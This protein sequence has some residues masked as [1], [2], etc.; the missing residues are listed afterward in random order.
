MKA[1]RG[2]DS[3]S[4]VPPL[5]HGLAPPHPEGAWGGLCLPLVWADLWTSLALL[6]FKGNAILQLHL[7]TGHS[8]KSPI[9]H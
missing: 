9:A 2:P 5:P 7:F 6:R 8:H 1:P 4:Q 3:P